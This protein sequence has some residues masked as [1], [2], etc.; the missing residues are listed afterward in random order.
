MFLYLTQA[1]IDRAVEELTIE[2][3]DMA[4]AEQE[5]VDEKVEEVVLSLADIDH[6]CK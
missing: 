1:K 4:E 3:Q 6:V 5:V 2:Q